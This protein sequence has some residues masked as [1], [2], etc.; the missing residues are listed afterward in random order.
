VPVKHDFRRIE[1]ES[2]ILYCADFFYN[3]MTKGKIILREDQN[4]F[5]SRLRFLF[6]FVAAKNGGCS[7]VG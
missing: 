4:A 3:S 2:K 6:N 7:S 5:G 1:E